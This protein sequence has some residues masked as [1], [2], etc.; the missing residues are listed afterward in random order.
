MLTSASKADVVRGQ[1]ENFEIHELSEFSFVKSMDSLKNNDRRRFHNLLF[2][3]ALMSC[4]TICRNFS[5]FA[6]KK[7]IKTC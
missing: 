7:V 1:N 4:K 2:R 6:I 5:V 3:Q